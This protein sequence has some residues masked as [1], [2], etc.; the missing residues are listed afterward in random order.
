LQAHTALTYRR[1]VTTSANPTAAVVAAVHATAPRRTA[2]IL[3]T[4]RRII[5]TTVFR[6][7]NA[8]L[9]TLANIV[10]TV[11][12]DGTP[13]ATLDTLPDTDTVPGNLAAESIKGADTRLAITVA[14]ERLFQHFTARA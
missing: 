4:D 14:T 9:V 8:A 12:H 1:F 6:A 11:V 5:T 2:A 3:E 7:V 13:T 10:T